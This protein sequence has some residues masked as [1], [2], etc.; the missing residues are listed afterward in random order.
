MTPAALKGLRQQLKLSQ[1]AFGAKV[2][3]SK[4]SIYCW[5]AGR[6]RIPFWLDAVVALMEKNKP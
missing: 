4:V 1:A 2:G 6:T 5:E 3:V